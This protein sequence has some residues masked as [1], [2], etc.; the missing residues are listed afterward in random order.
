M[1]RYE[2]LVEFIFVQ[3]I[4][5]FLPLPLHSKIDDCGTYNNEQCL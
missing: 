1:Q 3:P 4:N 5:L 2:I